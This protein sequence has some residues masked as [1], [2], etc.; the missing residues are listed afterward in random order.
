MSDTPR[1]D[2]EDLFN[3]D[4]DADE[5]IKKLK[6]KQKEMLNKMSYWFKLGENAALSL[7]NLIQ[8]GDPKAPPIYDLCY[9]AGLSSAELAGC[10][11]AYAVNGDQNLAD[12][13]LNIFAVS[14]Q[15]AFE[16]IGYDSNIVISVK[17]RTT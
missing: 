6:P 13:T 4:P 16:K 3:E 1:F 15:Q 7:S 8:M 2:P 10:Y 17:K 12:K 9:A 14:I 11:F 5:V